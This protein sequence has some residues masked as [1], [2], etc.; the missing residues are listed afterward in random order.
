M[1]KHPAPHLLFS[2]IFAAFALSALLALPACGFLGGDSKK[3]EQ[4]GSAPAKSESL[5]HKLGKTVGEAIGGAVSGSVK[6]TATGLTEDFKGDKGAIQR[7]RLGRGMTEK[8]FKVTSADTNG[9]METLTVYIVGPE[10]FE[11]SEAEFTAKLF[12]AADAEIG[13]SKVS[14]KWEADFASNVTFRF[15]KSQVEDAKWYEVEIKLPDAA[16][17]APKSAPAAAENADAAAAETVRASA[18]AK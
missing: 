11:G 2:D 10:Q 8:G 14:V 17:Q 13:R 15:G 3:A 9:V 7:V 4:Q 16:P 6:G 12:S 18:E 1:K 5:S